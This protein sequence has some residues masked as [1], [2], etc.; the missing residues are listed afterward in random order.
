VLNRKV[1]AILH[2]TSH[3]HHSCVQFDKK[4]RMIFNEKDY[5]EVQK[6]LDI[7]LK[8]TTENGINISF[9]IVL[10]KKEIIGLSKKEISEGDLL[11]ALVKIN[12]ENKSDISD[13]E[14]ELD[15]IIQENKLKIHNQ[16]NWK[17]FIPFNLN[18]SKKKFVLNGY[19]FK[20]MSYKSLKDDLN[21]KF[22]RKGF[23]TY[24]MPIEGSKISE[25]FLIV[26][27]KGLTL[28]DSYKKLEPTFNLLRGI[29]D[30][31][32]TNSTYNMLTE[33]MQ[34]QTK[35]AHPENIL[36][37]N[38]NQEF[39]YINFLVPK[40]NPKIKNLILVDSQK[41]KIIEYVN[42]FS[43]VDT[44][45]IKYFLTDCFRLYSNAMEQEYKH[46][47]FLSFWQLSEKLSLKDIN[48]GK[49]ETVVKRLKFISKKHFD[50]ELKGILGNHSSL[51]NNIVH[52]GIDS[53]T[54]DDIAILK[55][56]NE[57]IIFWIIENSKKI[58]TVGHY[59]KYFQFIEMNNSEKRAI[60]E[61]IEFRD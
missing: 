24:L 18:I 37:I 2:A 39:L 3:I 4:I 14:I 58:K 15:K 10:Y 35:I 60:K 55:Y 53:V 46:N 57:R 42:Y 19:E 33:Q 25:K 16:I 54:D 20:I 27:L 36:S 6:I 26:E 13:L 17:I 48:S 45:S 49:N 21:R 9:E 47:S 30:L 34:S 32:V 12:R 41:K 7:L 59:T 28:Y 11:K 38:E 43:H 61:M 22:Y 1:I 8:N 40:F 5:S 52:R 23:D 51:R 31:V 29:I 56:L 50:I 44:S